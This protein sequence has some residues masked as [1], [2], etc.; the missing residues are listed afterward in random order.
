[1]I[2]IHAAGI[3]PGDKNIRAE[4]ANKKFGL[5]IPFPFIPGND[6]SGE[7]AAVGPDVTEK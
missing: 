4:I 1:L 5:T 3:N 2:R 6:L 7:I